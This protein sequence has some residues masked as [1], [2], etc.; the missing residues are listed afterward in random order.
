MCSSVC[1]HY[2]QIIKKPPL[3]GRKKENMKYC[4][5]CGTENQDVAAFCRKCGTPFQQPVAPQTIQQPN[6]N[7]QQK[8]KRNKNKKKTISNKKLVLI[9]VILCVVMLMFASGEDSGTT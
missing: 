3:G 5:K 6:L 4:Q 9:L 8:S 1:F 2:Y 7:Q